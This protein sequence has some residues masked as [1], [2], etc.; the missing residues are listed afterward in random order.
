MDP[1]LAL[2]KIKQLLQANL[3]LDEVTRARILDLD[4]IAR[5]QVV[6]V[7]E[8]LN[9]KEHVLLERVVEKN[10]DFFSELE[11]VAITA[12]LQKFDDQREKIADLLRVE[13]VEKVGEL[14]E[15]EAF[16]NESLN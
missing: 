3:L 14:A 12:G 15:L 4:P 9:A 7:L 8:E 5:I 11:Q 10:P 16:L 6:P 13:A 2:N 1:R